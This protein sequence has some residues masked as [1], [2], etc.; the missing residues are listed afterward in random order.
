MTGFYGFYLVLYQT[1]LVVFDGFVPGYLMR[2]CDQANGRRQKYC[3]V[4]DLHPTYLDLIK[5]RDGL[6]NLIDW[7]NTY[8]REVTLARM[9][10][11]LVV[12]LAFL[13]IAAGK[14]GSFAFCFF[15]PISQSNETLVHVYQTLPP[16]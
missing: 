3:L 8:Y 12:Y 16:N 2:Q 13:A 11:L 7:H 1:R 15:L 4:I 9:K 6:L 5:L 10:F 14:S